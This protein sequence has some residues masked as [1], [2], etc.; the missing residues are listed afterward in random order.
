MRIFFW[1]FV[2]AREYVDFFYKLC[3]VRTVDNSLTSSYRKLISVR[4]C[5]SM[6]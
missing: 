3:G 1:R 4:I 2:Y 6:T 5:V